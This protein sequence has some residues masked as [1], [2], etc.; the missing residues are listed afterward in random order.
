MCG[1]LRLLRLSAVICGRGWT[2]RRLIRGETANP[3]WTSPSAGR[4]LYSP[5]RSTLCTNVAV[6]VTGDFVTR[7]ASFFAM[8]FRRFN[9]QAF[10]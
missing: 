2:Q 10:E 8:E 4:L 5:S 7:L 3:R 9:Y 1:D 6:L